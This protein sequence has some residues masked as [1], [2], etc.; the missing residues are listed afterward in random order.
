M[1]ARIMNTERLIA[2]YGLSEEKL[3][4]LAAVCEERKLILRGVEPFEADCTV[5]FLCGFAGYPPAA[6][7]TE[8]PKA[9]CLIFSGF[10]RRALS[11]TVDALNKAGARV[12]LK[13]VCT[14]SNR[15]WKLS[16]LIKE[17]E[18]EHAY[19]TGGGAK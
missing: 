9:E 2:A 6:G 17:L 14:D 8:P 13:A 18:K 3:S 1:K 19:M 16:D 5:G 4:A 10:D 15:S 11:E 12:P 7:C